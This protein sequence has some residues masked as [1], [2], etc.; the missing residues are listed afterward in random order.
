MV[1]LCSFSSWLA[2]VKDPSAGFSPSCRSRS[3]ARWGDNPSE[4]LN[5]DNTIKPSTNSSWSHVSYGGTTVPKKHE[6]KWSLSMYTYICTCI[7]A[8]RRQHFRPLQQRKATSCMKNEHTVLLTCHEPDSWNMISQKSE[9]EQ[10]LFPAHEGVKSNT[11]KRPVKEQELQYCKVTS[12]SFYLGRW[13]ASGMYWQASCSCRW[14]TKQ[15]IV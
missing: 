4:D 3:S 7:Y 9:Q 5:T 13:V 1:P 10:N 2:N 6:K 8:G 12:H 11:V 14:N 15:T